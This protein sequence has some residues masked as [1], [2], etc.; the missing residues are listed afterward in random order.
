MHKVRDDV[1]LPANLESGYLA[2]WT[3]FVG[4]EG[5]LVHNCPVGF[6]GGTSKTITNVEINRAKVRVDVEFPTGGS[7]GN[8]HVQVKGPG[9]G[10][11]YLNNL[12]D[13]AELPKSIR[14]NESIQRGVKKAFDLLNRYV[15]E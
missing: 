2:T 6:T 4:E 11:F 14:N 5:W 9:A 10:K 1:T 7:T 12:D 15:P 3:F 13:L 8:V